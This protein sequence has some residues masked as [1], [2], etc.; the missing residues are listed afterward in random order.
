MKLR[1]IEGDLWEIPQEGKM[2]V[3]GR[4]YSVGP[5]APDDAALQQVANVAHLPGILRFSLA[6]PDIHWGY[7]FPIGGVAAVDARHGAISP[8]GVGYDINCGVRL[9]T[10]GLDAAAARARVRPLAAQLFRDV[11][12]GVGSSAAIPRLSDDE[13]TDVLR[14]GARWAMRRGFAAADDDVARCEEGGRLAGADP[15][16]VSARARQRGADQ[17]GTLGSGNHFLEVDRVAEIHDEAA[18]E[19][20]GLR[21]GAVALQIHCGSRGLGYQVCDEALASLAASGRDLGE[22]YRDLPD[23]QLACAPVESE[24]GRAYL[25]AMQAAANFAWAN[26]QVIT[27]LAVRALARALGATDREVGARLLYDVCHNVAKH[28]THL[29][30]GRPREV[31]VHRKGAT[32]AFGPGDPRVPEPY[33]DVGQPVLIPGDMGRY[34]YVLAGTAR[35][36]DDTFGSSCHGAGRLL[37]RGQAMKAARGRSIARELAERGIEVVSRGKKTLAE[38]MS[39]AYKDVADVVG[40][41]ARAGITRLVARLE[42]LAVIKG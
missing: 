28:E 19:A 42:P 14:D 34:S 22:G 35:A 41:M 9:V 12:T 3:P 18:A 15:E 8:G 21:P 4:V 33:R 7:G 17:V 36:M 25:G 16:A 10:T 11:P 38:E 13:L 5:P 40:V 27:G 32:R 29:V 2:R 24:P 26:R 39:D 23:P 20:F 1:R 30:D 6:M 37:S 31:L